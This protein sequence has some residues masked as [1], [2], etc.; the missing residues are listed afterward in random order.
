ME[1]IILTTIIFC[2]TL[3]L[4]LS[5]QNILWKK[6]YGLTTADDY[7]RAVIETNDGGIAIVGYTGSYGAGV[8]MSG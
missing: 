6:N 4:S 1:K 5:A 3:T 8:L 7:G 2:T